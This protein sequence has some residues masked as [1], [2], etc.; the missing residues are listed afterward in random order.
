MT[1]TLFVCGTPIGNLGDI[2]RRLEEVLQQ[3]DL[4]AAEDT[5]RSSQLLNHLG[6][7][8]PLVSYHEHNLRKSGEALMEKLKSGMNIAL[9]SDAGMPGISD[10][11]EVLIES[12][13]REGIHVELIAGPV[14]G[15][16]ALILSGLPTA[17]FAFEG[18]PDRNKKTRRSQFE[19]LVRDERT[20]IFYEAPHRLEATL[21]DMLACFGDRRI[22]VARELTK[23]YE[24]FVRGTVT[25][26]IRHFEA[27][28]P[29]GE[30][31]IVLAGA[32]PLEAGT[33]GAEAPEEDEVLRELMN[34][35]EEG[36][37]RKDAAAEVA[38]LYGLSKKE[39]YKLSTQV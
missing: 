1:G 24:E 34:R 27:Q 7:R 13:I 37:S 22:A 8:K 33:D 11:G 31:V 6:I 21:K 17:R 26:A 15:I 23:R 29:K 12:C 5:R 2:S 20:L 25:E 28:A 16:H 18:F 3:A 30:F 19:A 9:V 4:V 14:A 36:M 35:V 39:V 10:P 32:D 38:A